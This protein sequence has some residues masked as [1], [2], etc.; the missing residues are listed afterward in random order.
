MRIEILAARLAE[1]TN[2]P[3]LADFLLGKKPITELPNDCM[4]WTG[5]HTP[6]GVRT[7][8]DRDVNNIPVRYRTVRRPMGQIQANGKSEYVHRL[9]FKLLTKPDFEFHMRNICGQSLCCNP[10]HWDVSTMTPEL[11]LDT[12]EWTPE[13]VEET[14]DAMLGRLSGHSMFADGAALRR[15]QMCADCRVVDLMRNE[16]GVDIRDV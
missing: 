16:R 4:I 15:L 12:S 7:V 13:E 6:A 8:M 11:I 1:K 10:K 14:V 9:V 2:T 5:K 3:Q